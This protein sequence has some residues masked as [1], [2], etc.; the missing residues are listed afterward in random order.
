MKRTASRSSRLR[1]KPPPAE[2]REFYKKPIADALL[3]LQPGNF[4]LQ[5]PAHTFDYIIHVA[6]LPVPVR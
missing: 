6:S 3:P 2:S 1:L 4:Y 5:A